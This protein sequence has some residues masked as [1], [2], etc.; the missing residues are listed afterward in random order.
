MNSARLLELVTDVADMLGRGFLGV[1][2]ADE[3]AGGGG[4]ASSYFCLQS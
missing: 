1:L 4:W 2:G 3:I